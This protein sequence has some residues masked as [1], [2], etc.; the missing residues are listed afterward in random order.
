MGTTCIVSV[1]VEHHMGPM[2]FVQG[3]ITL[4]TD[5][6]SPGG[7]GLDLSDY[8][9]EIYIVNLGPR[10]G[11]RPSWDKANKKVKMY[12]AGADAAELDEVADATDLNA[13]LLD[14]TAWGKP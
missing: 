14:F 6:E 13:E 5:Y 4:P 12:E 2:K 7:S 8:L 9:S 10:T 1:A 11:Y 3:T